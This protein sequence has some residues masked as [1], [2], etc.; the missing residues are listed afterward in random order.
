[1]IIDAHQHF[2]QF[3]PVRDTWMG[4]AIQRDFLPEDLGPVLTANGVEACVA[5][6]ADQSE[7]ETQFLLGLAGKHDFIKG[8]VGWVD[9]RADN[10]EERLQYF[11]QFPA[12]KGFRHIVQGEPDDRFLL[13][14]DFCNGISLL[15]KY[16]FTYDIL[17]FPHQLP[18]VVEFVS[19]FPNQRFVIDHLA[20]PDFKKGLDHEWAQHIR[21]IAHHRNVYCKL[22]GMVTEADWAHWKQEDF[23]PMIEVVLTAFGS[24]R[25]MF[26]SDWPVC[27]LA[28]DYAEVKRILENYISGFSH[29]EVGMIMGGN[30]RTFY[31]L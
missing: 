16:N 18:A 17:V 8:V 26:G 1:M 22:S 24:S 20:K 14:E 11:S 4:P 19:K 13:R 3:D 5:V 12:L 9:L 27:L 7:Q 6:Q 29:S 21:A 10:I 15:A 31:K 23:D 25:V 2:W 28:A 30:A